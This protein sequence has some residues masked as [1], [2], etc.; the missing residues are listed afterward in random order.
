MQDYC[1]R[2]ETITST[3]EG[4]IAGVKNEF[5]DISHRKVF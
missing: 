5:I 4:S 2:G 1:T 3:G